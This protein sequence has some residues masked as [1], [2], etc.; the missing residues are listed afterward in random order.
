MCIDL[1]TSPRSRTLVRIQDLFVIPRQFSF[2]RFIS[3]LSS[4]FMTEEDLQIGEYDEALE[5]GW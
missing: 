4:D 3:L 5:R 2:T 1:L